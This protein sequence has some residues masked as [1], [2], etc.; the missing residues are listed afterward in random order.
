MDGQEFRGWREGNRLTQQQIADKFGVSRNTIQNW[1]NSVSSVPNAVV[2]SCQIW[3]ERL[4]QE[5]PNRGPVTL[6]YSD[7]PMFINPYGPRRQ[8]AMMEQEPYVSNAA[9]LARVQQL[10]RQDTFHNPFV[11]EE[12]GASLW[13]TV[14]LQRVANGDD[15]KAP[16]LVNLLRNISEDVRTNS[17][18]FVRHGARRMEPGA[19]A[20]RQQATVEQAD[21]LERLSQLGSHAIVRDRL[22]VEGVFRTLLSLGTKAPD[23][24]VVAVWDAVTVFER[25]PMPESDEPR[26][27]GGNMILDYKAFRISWP[28]IPLF[29]NKWDVNVGTNNRSLSARLGRGTVFNDNASLENAIANAKARID[30]ITGSISRSY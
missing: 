24:L 16:T 9:V 20:K 14:E 12:S 29:S 19:A 5:D 21:E 2:T 3:E 1:E 4:K 27:D 11:I 15:L 23:N 17:A 22:K 10:W 6:I 8:P 13:N 7:G 25:H 30:E 18:N 28:K 26:Q